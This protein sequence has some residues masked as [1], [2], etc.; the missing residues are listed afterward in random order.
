MSV[1]NLSANGYPASDLDVEQP[2]PDTATVCNGRLFE[3]ANVCNR[4]VQFATTRRII[5]PK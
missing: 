2:F 4:T 1:N 3:F 5:I